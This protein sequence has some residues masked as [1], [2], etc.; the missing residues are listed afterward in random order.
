VNP[1]LILVPIDFS[2]TG[3]A[4][5]EAATALARSTSGRLPIVHIVEHQGLSENLVYSL[6]QP[7]VSTEELT[8]QLRTVV[9]SD[10]SVPYEHRLLRGAPI[11]RILDVAESEQV[12]LI[13]IGTHGRRG[14]DRVLMGSV[15]EAVVRRAKCPVLAVKTEASTA[16][17]ATR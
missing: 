10:K 15:A 8:E 9:P 13:V 2:P 6:V 11:D 7:H 5:L 16:E 17:A 14:L 4:S 12:D 3:S 1:Q